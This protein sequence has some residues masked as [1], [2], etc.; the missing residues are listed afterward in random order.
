MAHIGELA[1]RIDLLV[2]NAG[3]GSGLGAIAPERAALRD[4]F[5]TNVD[6]TIL[7]TEPMLPLVRDGGQVVF[8]SSKMGLPA[9]AAPDG[10]A[11]RISKAAI[12]MY[13]ASL[14]QRVADQAIAVTPMHPGW[15]QTRMGGASA[16]FTVDQLAEG[17][18][19]G[20]QARPESGKFWKVETD[21]LVA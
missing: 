16:P 3:V 5:A 8:L 15:G 11:Y 21:S 2:N 10:P 9:F 1:P 14:A 12:N 4:T 13:A 20:I 17:L 6:G 7:F 18:F 19:R